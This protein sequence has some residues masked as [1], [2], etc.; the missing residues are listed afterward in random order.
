MDSF[1]PFAKPRD[2]GPPPFLV[3]LYSSTITTTTSTTATTSTTTTSTSS[4]AI[5]KQQSRMD[6]SRKYVQVNIFKIFIFNNITGN[7]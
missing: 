1:F 2:T 6:S 7:M 3:S 4:T 5:A